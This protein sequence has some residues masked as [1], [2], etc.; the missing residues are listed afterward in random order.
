ML[1]S[2]MWVENVNLILS[3]DTGSRLTSLLALKVQ[4]LLVNA[5]C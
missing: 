4:V 2:D 1:T 5:S 3:L